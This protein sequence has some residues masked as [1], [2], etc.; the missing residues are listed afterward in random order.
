MRITH[1]QTRYCFLSELILVLYNYLHKFL[2][3]FDFDMYE[4]HYSGSVATYFRLVPS[5]KNKYDYGMMVLILTFNLVVVSGAHPG[6]KVWDI[7]RERFLIILM[8]FI[9]CICVSLFV[10]PLWASDEFHDSIISRFH[11]L[12]NTIEGNIFCF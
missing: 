1:L 10:F 8:G 11:D 2:Q 9:V 3:I 6:L 12:A 7:A 4:I 5:I